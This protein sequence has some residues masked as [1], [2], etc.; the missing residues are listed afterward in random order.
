VTLVL[1]SS[2]VLFRGEAE[3]KGNDCCMCAWML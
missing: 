1:G 2:S 3:D